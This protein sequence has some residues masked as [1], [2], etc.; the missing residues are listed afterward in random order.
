M[1]S[2]FSS[3]SCS[4]T[5][6]GI[7]LSLTRDISPERSCSVIHFN[8]NDLFAAANSGSSSYISPDDCDCAKTEKAYPSADFRYDVLKV[9]YV[10]AA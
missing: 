4:S 3:S 6:N 5:L 2:M 10:S 1:I 9:N 7:V 8:S